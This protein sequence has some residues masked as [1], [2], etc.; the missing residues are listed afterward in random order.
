MK[1]S[2]SQNKLGLFMFLLSGFKDLKFC[3]I[4]NSVNSVKGIKNFGQL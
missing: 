1:S 4:L 2:L 3:P